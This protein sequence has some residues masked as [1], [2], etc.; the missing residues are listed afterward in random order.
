MT[1]GRG[2]KREEQERRGKNMGH[3]KVSSVQ[4]VVKNALRP[5][6]LNMG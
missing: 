2:L 1:S 3:K 4:R 5:E 6:T